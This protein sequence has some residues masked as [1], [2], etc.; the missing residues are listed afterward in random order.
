MSIDR[1]VAFVESVDSLPDRCPPLRWDMR[2]H[3]QTLSHPPSWSSNP[4]VKSPELVHTNLPEQL[5]DHVG[6]VKRTPSL[7]MGPY[8][9]SYNVYIHEVC[10]PDHKKIG[11]PRDLET[12]IWLHELAH[13]TQF[14]TGRPRTSRSMFERLFQAPYQIDYAQ[15]EWIASLAICVF[16]KTHEIEPEA[17]YWA[18]RDLMITGLMLECSKTVAKLMMLSTCYEETMRSVDVL[19]GV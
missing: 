12:F 7:A 10:M 4:S 19:E 6:W 8:W 15:E 3:V 11:T 2:E 13:A 17:L 9:P 14:V 16:L 1:D 18:E 5:W